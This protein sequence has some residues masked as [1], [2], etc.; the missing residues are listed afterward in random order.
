LTQA[1]RRPSPSRD[2]M[3]TGPEELARL[4]RA[5]GV[6]DARVLQAIASVPRAAFVPPDH[7][8]LAYRDEPIRIPHGQ[9]TTQP[10]LVARM[11]EALALEGGERVLEVGTGYGF[12]TAMLAQLA[13]EVVSLERFA[14]L[15]DAARRNL[16]RQGITGVDVLVADGSAGCPE[17][18][19]F[20]AIVV[21]AAFT[22]VPQPLAEQ[23]GEGGRLVQPVGPGG[24]DEVVLFERG[25]GGLE[26]ARTVTPAH[27]VKLYGAHGFR[28][29]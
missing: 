20:E 23:L 1:A 17:R 22:S 14:D 6:R 24:H 3:S 2:R 27:F 29:V 12:Q 15:A 11:L 13:A 10:S 5:T 25:A 18:A 9:V 8:H 16:E 28:P 4:V 7:V 26:R 21:S 19:P